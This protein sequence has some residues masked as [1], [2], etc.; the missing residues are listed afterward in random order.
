MLARNLRL[1]ALKRAYLLPE[2]LR[3]LC[4]RRLGSLECDIAQTQSML[5]ICD[6]GFGGFTLFLKSGDLGLAATLFRG[7]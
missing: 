6:L 2:V 7:D 1:L 5:E 3:C 4:K